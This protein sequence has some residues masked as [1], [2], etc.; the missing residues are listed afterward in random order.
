MKRNYKYLTF[1]GFS[2]VLCLFL[3]LPAFA[4]RGGGGHAGGG[5][6]SGGGGHM[7]GGFSGG[8]H[9]G[10]GF[11]GGAGRMGSGFSG[12]R[13]SMGFSGARSGVAFNPQRSA[14]SAQRGGIS[15]RGI[16]NGR[17]YG[18]RIG[19]LNGS[20]TYAGAYG[21]GAFGSSAY[22]RGAFGQGGY[23]RGRGMG[24]YG[25]NRHD[26]Y[27][28][29]HGYYG[30][31]YYPM[32]GFGCGY[33]PYGYYPF[34]WDDD[35]YFFSNGF[36]YQYNNDQYTVVEPPVG[37][38]IKDLPSDAQSIVINGQQYYEQNGVYYLPVTKDDG[39]T[40][41]QV[42]GKDGELNTDVDGNKTVVPQIGDIVTTLPPD[43]RKITIKGDS[44]FVSQ[45]GIYYQEITDG[46]SKTTYKIVGLESDEPEN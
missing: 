38:A 3:I 40:V 9:M 4:Q 29:N 1:T 12:G 41:Y 35:E 32:L 8:G 27:F 25:W 6:F 15:S 23:G 24:N 13:P 19:G 43:C 14:V 7:G 36:Y 20:R 2:A 11:S 30:S 37:A 45:D 39:S 42:A 44:Y 21:R 10:G 33:L 34:F 22:G 17:Q 18:N 46:S 16:Y 26:G 5:G 28:Y 31:A